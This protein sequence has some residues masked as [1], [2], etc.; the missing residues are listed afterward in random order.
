[1][2]SLGSGQKKYIEVDRGGIWMVGWID[3]KGI[4]WSTI[5]LRFTIEIIY[6]SSDSIYNIILQYN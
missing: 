3:G 6:S 5:Y 4:K 2:G 1:M